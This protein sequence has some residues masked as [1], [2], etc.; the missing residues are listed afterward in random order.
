[1]VEITET[2]GKMAVLRGIGELLFNRHGA[3]FSPDERI[4]KMNE[5]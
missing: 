3:S 2:G 4:I 5:R 1:M